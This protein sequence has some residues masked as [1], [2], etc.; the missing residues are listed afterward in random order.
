VRPLRIVVS[1]MV[2]GDPDQGGATWA[3][4]QYVLGLRRL[5][6]EVL[7][8]E[9]VEKLTLPIAASFA[10]TTAQYGLQ[11]TSALVTRD[12][13]ESWGLERD[14]LRVRTRRADVLINASGLLLDPELTAPIPIRVY[15][16]LDPGFTQLWADVDGID[17]GFDGHTHFVTVGGVIGR[18]TCA[19]PTCGL[20][21]IP[22]LPPVVL[23]HWPFA[24]RATTGV[25]TTVA[26]WRAYGSIEH[27]GRHFGQK[28]H[29]LRR[30]A[31]IPKRSS[32]T[33][34]LALSIHSQERSDLQTL[35]E[36]RWQLLDPVAAAGTAV[37]YHRFVQGSFAEIGIAKSGYVE[38]RCGWFSDRSAAYL[39][40]GRPVLAQDTGFAEELPVGEGLLSFRDE[41]GAVAAAEAVSSN[42]PSHRRAARRVAE[43]FLDSDRVLFG[44]LEAVG[45]R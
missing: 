11:G 20:D 45:A 9:P 34:A 18:P 38:S 26:N 24:E 13:Q 40:S 14:A 8:V 41:D 6:H 43:E 16:D 42:Y 17:M 12:S 21:W 37:G 1:G 7:L 25:F 4:L 39:A 36:N 22:T 31:G 30:L 35:R 28:A 19:V 29:S 33:F 3:V 10:A 32:R 15:L 44:L 27:D 2:A 5:G 23:D